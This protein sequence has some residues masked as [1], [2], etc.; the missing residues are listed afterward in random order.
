[1]S[2]NDSK[3]LFRIDP[4]TIYS[5]EA[6]ESALAGIVSLDQFILRVNPKRAFKHGFWGRDLIE[7]L[8]RMEGLG[9]NDPAIPERRRVR[10][11][12]DRGLTSSR[13]RGRER[14]PGLERID[15]SAMRD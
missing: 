15:P 5:R 1:M 8:D 13:R 12:L 14:P 7:A 4:C 10:E 11:K 2:E 6:L 9:P 3:P